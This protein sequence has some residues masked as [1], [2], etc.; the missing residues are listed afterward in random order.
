ME[1]IKNKNIKLIKNLLDAAVEKDD[2]MI[3]WDLWKTLYPIM[4]TGL[5]EFIPFK[6]F[7]ENAFRKDH[8]YTLKSKEEIE[9][10]ILGI[11]EKYERR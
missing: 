2:E 6:E 4:Q 5:I 3:A 1:N 10:E 7:K 11:V 9:D 8:K